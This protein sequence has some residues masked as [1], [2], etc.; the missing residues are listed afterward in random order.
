MR[1]FLGDIQITDVLLDIAPL[2]N[3]L[4]TSK[5]DSLATVSAYHNYALPKDN[6]KNRFS[7]QKML[8]SEIKWNVTKQLKFT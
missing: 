1:R 6:H 2:R 3:F 4:G 8:C 5:N 7:L